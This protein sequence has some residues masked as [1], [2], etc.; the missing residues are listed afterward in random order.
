MS[1]VSLKLLNELELG[2]LFALS[3][4]LRVTKECHTFIR[5]VVHDSHY[6]G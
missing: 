3:F 4:D 1:G 5:D 6:A 2:L